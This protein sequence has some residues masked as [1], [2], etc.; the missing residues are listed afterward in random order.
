MII[1][2]STK[3]VSFVIELRLRKQVMRD[4]FGY[5]LN[6]MEPEA[7]LQWW[8]EHPIIL[9]GNKHSKTPGLSIHYIP[10]S[11]SSAFEIL[12]QPVQQGVLGFLSEFLESLLG[13]AEH[14]HIDITISSGGGD[15]PQQI[16][17]TIHLTVGECMD[18]AYGE[19]R[20]FCLQGKP[21]EWRL[22]YHSH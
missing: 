15:V 11:D 7:F 3:P 22:D 10:Y 5:S 12:I 4:M 9:G 13:D 2:F 14:R 20:W 17:G 8:N 21:C 16:I 19:G 6:T 18:V 1:Y